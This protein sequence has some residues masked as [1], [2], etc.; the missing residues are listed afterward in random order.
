MVGLKNDVWT[1]FYEPLSNVDTA[2]ILSTLVR[3]KSRGWIQLKSA[4]PVDPP[5]IDPRYYSHPDDIQVMLEG[6]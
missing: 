4:D 3:P 1:K 6:D 5:V 2:S